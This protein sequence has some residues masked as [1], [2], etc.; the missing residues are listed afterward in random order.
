MLCYSDLAFKKPKVQG[1]RLEPSSW[2]LGAAHLTEL[3]L[4]PNDYKLKSYFK[5]ARTPTILLSN[6]RYYK[7]CA[8][9][10][11]ILGVLLVPGCTSPAK[12]TD[13]FFRPGG[14]PH[15]RS[16]T[17]QNYADHEGSARFRLSLG[18]HSDWTGSFK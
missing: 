7:Y 1:V 15:V 18:C 16:T 12:L 11:L 3:V 14:N 6:S 13:I 2:G 5:R 10:T 9:P 4:S 8:S 17:L